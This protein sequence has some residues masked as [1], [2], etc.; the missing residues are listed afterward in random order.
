M[1]EKDPFD[2]FMNYYAVIESA[3]PV[4]DREI[5]IIKCDDSNS[6]TFIRFRT[7][8]QSFNGRNRNRRLWIQRFMEQMLN[9]KEVHE[10][11]RIGGLPG[12]AGHPV[13]DIGQATV[14][15][16]LTI[17]PLRVSHY[18]T[19]FE[20]VGKKL[21]GIVETADDGEG[22]PGYRLRKFILQGKIPSFSERAL[23]PQQK[24]RD[25]SSDQTG[26]GRHVGHDRVFLPSHDDAYMDTEFLIKSVT[27]KQNF[28][29]AMES[30]CNY[31]V[32][33]SEKVKQISDGLSPV[34][35]SAAIDINGSVSFDVPDGK[36]IIPTERQYREELKDYMRSFGR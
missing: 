6:A 26:P 5:E 24:N 13:P 31:V 11:L 34:M 2:N 19:K 14:E 33:R 22:A 28:E 25:G 10:M 3:V 9:T 1:R 20:W 21:Y 30:Y 29:T 16:I 36:I 15:R 27:T 23:I 17:D 8:L 18:V 35:E 12:E 7:C 4:E 32:E